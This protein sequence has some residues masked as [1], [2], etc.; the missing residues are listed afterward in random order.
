MDK[1]I[2][3]KIKTASYSE[4]IQILNL[5]PDKWSGMHCSEYVFE[6]LLWTLHE[7]K[8]VGQILAKPT[9]KK[10]KT[11]TIE[12]LHLVTHVYEDDNFSR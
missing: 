6:C 2:Q 1:A 3:E 10:G 4:Q 7:I 11:I 5:V 9:P 12:T 8:D